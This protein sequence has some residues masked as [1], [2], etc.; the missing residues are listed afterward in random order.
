MGKPFPPPFFKV[1]IFNSGEMRKILR[2]LT[3]VSS[4]S[5]CDQNVLERIRIDVENLAKMVAFKTAV[6]ETLNPHKMLQMNLKCT[7]L[8][9][10]GKQ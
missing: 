7:L 9:S 5:K 8:S 1:F 10:K 3:D 6:G 2:Q 4:K